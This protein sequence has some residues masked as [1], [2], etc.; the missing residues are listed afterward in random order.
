MTIKMNLW[1]LD[2]AHTGWWI[3][4]FANLLILLS[5][6]GYEELPQNLDNLGK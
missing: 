2:I 3:L 5:A 1:T 6:E 4:S